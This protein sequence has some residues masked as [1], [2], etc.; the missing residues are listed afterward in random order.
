MN[1][2]SPF[3]IL[4]NDSSRYTAK[5]KIPNCKIGCVKNLTITFSIESKSHQETKGMGE[6]K[7]SLAITGDKEK[8]TATFDLTNSLTRCILEYHSC[9]VLKFSITF[10]QG[11]K[12]HDFHTGFHSFNLVISIHIHFP[13]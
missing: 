4:L 9:R 7:L 1:V 2:Y 3:V 10:Q 12:R 8:P 11:A 6:E 5:K 13:T